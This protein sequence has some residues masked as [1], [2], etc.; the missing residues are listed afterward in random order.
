MKYLLLPIILF[1]VNVFALQ[2][3]VH[4]VLPDGETKNFTFYQ[5]ENEKY[6]DIETKLK[7]IQCLGMFTAESQKQFMVTC[8]FKDKKGKDT[9]G[10]ASVTVCGVPDS[11]GFLKLISY[12]DKKEA[13]T[14]LS[15]SC[16]K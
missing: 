14:V 4:V 13:Q 15:F 1:S 9:S 2:G 10:T 16:K 8:V 3:E 12:L 5:T 7:G 11:I 6:F